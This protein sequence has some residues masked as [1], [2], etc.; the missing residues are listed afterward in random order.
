MVNPLFLLETSLIVQYGEE[1]TVFV[2]IAIY[3]IMGH[4]CTSCFPRARGSNL[5]ATRIAGGAALAYNQLAGGDLGPQQS[6][7]GVRRHLHV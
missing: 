7:A 5:F 2:G 3:A 1:G 4:D 6:W